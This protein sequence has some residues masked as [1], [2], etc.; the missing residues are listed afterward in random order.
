MET[1]YWEQIKNIGISGVWLF[2]LYIT[3]VTL[4]IGTLGGYGF[5]KKLNSTKHQE[6]KTYTVNQLE[7]ANDDYI[8]L[9]AKISKLNESLKIE[10][11]N[12]TDDKRELT[13]KTT[14]L[15]SSFDEN[16][17]KEFKG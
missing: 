11:K 1:N 2:L 16:M 10:N 7:K 15:K 13:N 9:K 6:G 3:L 8:S 4:V 5:Q 17:N 12:K 14:S